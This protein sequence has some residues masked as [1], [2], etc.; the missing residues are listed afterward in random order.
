MRAPKNY[1]RQTPESMAAMEV[2]P[3]SMIK[4]AK[5]S[6]KTKYLPTD[7]ISIIIS[8]CEKRGLI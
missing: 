6:D 1:V 7:E 5:E 8:E 2:I 3:S 4:I